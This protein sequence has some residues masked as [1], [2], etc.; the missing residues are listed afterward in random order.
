MFM[1]VLFR[2]GSLGSFPCQSRSGWF[3]SG[4]T[5]DWRSGERDAVSV[6]GVELLMHVLLGFDYI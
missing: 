5:E 1:H 4:N 6:V 2:G 3:G